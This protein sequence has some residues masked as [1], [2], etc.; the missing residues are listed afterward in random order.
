MKRDPSVQSNLDRID[1]RKQNRTRRLK[2]EP[3]D[4]TPGDTILIKDDVLIRENDKWT[5]I[6]KPLRDRIAILETAL[7]TLT[8][9]TVTA[10]EN[11]IRELSVQPERIRETEERDIQV[12]FQQTYSEYIESGNLQGQDE[13][14]FSPLERDMIEF[15]FGD[16]VDKDTFCIEVI[17]Q[18]E[19][20]YERS[21]GVYYGKRRVM[22][23][24]TDLHPYVDDINETSTVDDT[25]ILKPPNL[26]YFQTIVHEATHHWQNIHLDFISGGPVRN[27]DFNQSQLLDFENLT[28]EQHAQAVSIWFLVAW[29]LEHTPDGS[30]IDLTSRDVWDGVGSTDRYSRISQIPYVN[31]DIEFDDGNVLVTVQKRIVSEAVAESILSDF[32]GLIDDLRTDSLVRRTIRLIRDRKP[33]GSPSQQN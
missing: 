32:E 11:G 16:I 28:T 29:Q 6:T 25:E 3:S 5:N 26:H 22:S 33:G 8:D 13:R 4:A 1:R 23:L 30:N 10:L 24:A 19:D 14:P 18:N 20:P 31:M 21:S 2:E 15:V 7:T 12:R 9:E 17:K 27:Y